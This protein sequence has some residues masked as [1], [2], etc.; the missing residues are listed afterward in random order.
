[1]KRINLF[2]VALFCAFA[3]NAA[4]RTTAK[5]IDRVIINLL[6]SG[7]KFAVLML[8]IYDATKIRII[9]Y[10]CRGF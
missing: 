10:L 3:V 5:A 8:R 9:L 1:M 2:L 6:I 7:L 4:E